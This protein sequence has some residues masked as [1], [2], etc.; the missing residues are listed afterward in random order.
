MLIVVLMCHHSIINVGVNASLSRLITTIAIRSGH[1][2]RA[3]P[4]LEAEQSPHPSSSR[5]PSSGSEASSCLAM[6]TSPA[7]WPGVQSRPRNR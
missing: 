6:G 1:A 4:H 5:R 7:S 2:D 3:E